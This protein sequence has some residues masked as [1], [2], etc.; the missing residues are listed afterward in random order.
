MFKNKMN[1]YGFMI[2]VGIWALTLLLGI[3]QVPWMTQAG[4]Y[5]GVLMVFF[6]Y[7]IAKEGNLGFAIVG[8]IVGIY[9][10]VTALGASIPGLGSLGMA[11]GAM[12]GVAYIFFAFGFINHKNKVINVMGWLLLLVFILTP[13]YFIPV[14]GTILNNLLQIAIGAIFVYYLAS[15]AGIDLPGNID[16]KV[17]EK[18]G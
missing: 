5:L 1:S 18:I 9:G 2:L 6:F 11:G 8:L 17:K 14:F 12:M 7:L 3:F 4:M 15:E 10:S 13:L 16:E